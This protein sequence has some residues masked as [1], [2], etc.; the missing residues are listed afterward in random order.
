[1][2]A[3]G[4]ISGKLKFQGNI[5]VIS[6]TV[7][8]LII[9]IAV[10][11]SSGFRHAI[12]DG[13]AAVM[14]DVQITSIG[15]SSFGDSNP[16]PSE[17]PSHDKILSIPGVASS[18]PVAFGAGIVKNEDIIHGI[19]LKGSS[20]YNDSS[21]TVSIP[22]RLSEITGLKEGDPMVTYFVGEKMKVRKFTVA[23]VY[24]D[25]VAFDDNLIVNA[26]LQDVQRVNGWTPSEAS[27]HEV[28]LLPQARGESL[29]REI[30]DR[31]GATL[32][33]SEDEDEQS[34]MTTTSAN[35]YPQLFDWLR[36]LDFNVV[37]ILILMIIVAGFNMIS[38]L[39][40]MLFRNISTIGTLKT[41][42]M[43]DRSIGKVFLRVS[44]GV[45]LKGMLLGNGLGLLFC[46][47]QSLTHFIK[48]DPA[49]YFVSYVPVH[50]NI[51]LILGA[52]V[53]AY[54]AIMLLLLIPTL[55]I[56][57]VDPSQT[58]KMD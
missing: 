42:G 40:I 26:S 1:M 52:D 16:I 44:S 22:R 24:E 47:V 43:T 34:L 4:F 8:F 30:S 14:G 55:F 21:M 28:R 32:M 53:F 18:S 6:I 27:L 57:R 50:V 41:L 31:I 3:S 56:A 7:S 49:S 37:F 13:V 23:S 5:A 25:L 46:L 36:L 54:F 2:D 10:A 38:G 9:I 58:V 51:P 45:V 29:S 39:L 19:I 48:L 11:V 17:L 15:S 35:R 33:L 12:R 20:D